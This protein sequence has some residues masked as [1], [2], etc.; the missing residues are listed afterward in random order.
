MGVLTTPDA[1]QATGAPHVL[2]INSGVIHRVGSSRLYVELARAL[3]ATGIYALRFDLSGIGDSKRR[4]DVESVRESVERDIGDAIQYMKTSQGA[5]QVILMGLCSGAFDAFNAALKQPTVVGAIM[6]D[7]PGPFR[8]WQHT[9]RHIASRL[10]RKDSWRNPLRKLLGH[11]RTL[12]NDKMNQRPSGGRYV[13]GAR[14]SASRDRM[15][16]ALDA[17]LA[18]GV[19]LHFTFTAGLEENY[20][21]PGQFKST[22]PRAARHPALSYDFFPEPDHSFGTR[23]M[24]DRLIRRTVD[25]VLAGAN[26]RHEAQH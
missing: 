25:W 15:R 4:T 7:L 14:G 16:D 22:F 5:Q 19:R 13:V 17:L 10:F 3:A 18:R 6:V 20:N 12:V 1:R 11:S 9:V 24:R 21:H 8:G 23:A 2:L 26:G